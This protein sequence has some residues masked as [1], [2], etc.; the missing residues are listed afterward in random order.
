[1]NEVAD[2][3]S[4]RQPSIV[5]R[6]S[7]RPFAAIACSFS[8]GIASSLLCQH[9]FFAGFAI[10]DIC[11]IYSGF[12]SLLKNRL[13]LS[14]TLGIIA[15]SMGG[16]LMALAN[17]DAFPES[18]LRS[19]ISKLALRLGEPVSSE[20]CVV[21]E[22]ELRGDEIVATID[23][24]AFLDKDRWIVTAGKAMVRIA[25]A[26]SENPG[27]KK[28]RLI[29][30][31]RV[32]GW[33]AWNLPRNFENPG[34]ADSAGLLARRGIILVGKI[35]SKRLLET[36]PGGCIDPWTRIANTIGTHVQNSLDPLRAIEKG[37]R[38]AILASLILGDYSGLANNTREVFQNSGTF[39][40]LVISGLHVAWIAGVL[41]QLLKWVWVPERI[42]YML[43]FFIILLY[44]CVVGFQASISRCLWMVLLYLIGRMIFRKAD[45]VNIL[46]SAAIFLLISQ[47]TWLFEPG[48][49]LSFLSVL[50]IAVTAVPA[51]NTYVTPVCRPVCF[52]GNS[53]RLF[54][55]PGPWHR[56]GRRLRVH[57]ELCIESIEDS[58]SPICARIL[59]SLSRCL[60][61]LGLSTGCAIVTSLAV[62]LW[63]QPLLAFQFN[64]MSWISP[65]ANIVVVPMSSAVLGTGAAAACAAN[66]PW[67]GPRLMG[68]AGSLAALLL[69][70][71]ARI[72]DI[73]G[74][75]QRC[76][77]PSVGWVLGGIL[78]LF[79]WSF[80]EWRRFWI[81][82]AGI[83][84]FLAAVACGS[85]P[86]LGALLEHTHLPG[87][88][89]GKPLWE[90]RQV[91]SLTFLDVGEGD[92]IVIRFPGMR[93]WVLDAGGLR[94]PPSHEDSAY[95]FDIGEAVVSRYLWQL[96][97]NPVDR[98]LISHP[99]M[100]HAGGI[101]AVLRNFKV[102]SFGY[103]RA[104]PDKM[105]SALMGVASEKRIP[106]RQLHTTIEAHIDGVDLQVL[107]PPVDKLF[108]TTNENS[109]TLRLSYH[110]FAAMLT[111]DL[112]KAGETAVLSQPGALDC[113]L[114]KIAHHGSRA[115][116]SN[117]FLDRT[118]PRWAVLSAGRNNPFG[119]P[120][121]ETFH[122]ILRHGVRP[123]STMDQGAITLETDG[124][125][126][127]LKSYLGGILES[128]EL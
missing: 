94:Q 75:W 29:R 45:S 27:E 3:S 47:P 122:R 81:P 55:Q 83:A 68:L 52:A 8:L 125:R 109:L 23:F 22:S 15:I 2:K 18:D 118:K 60:A 96:W 39:H 30:G 33:A 66:L 123:F 48:F 16:L 84:L 11:L 38:A 40:V 77:T 21:K 85:V 121:Q 70:C 37:Q 62:Q 78:L 90:N 86:V 14:F 128:G 65:F 26:D 93:T 113:Q 108:T 89:T 50:A 56:I 126:Y 64:R 25:V 31:D 35:K 61:Y 7:E 5:N 127:I 12:L 112:E 46:L 44:T 119:H 42:R 82:C 74:A 1:M 91:L 73:P 49:Q 95:V 9:Y 24:R 57:C 63:L 79:V 67:L 28:L 36:I 105:I 101:A 116:T 120:A 88:D 117:T 34:S 10:A 97:I 106:I 99:D 51:I 98:V 72:A 92:S 124:K 104:G 87:S 100:D 102:G 54:L 53:E 80:F 114:L 4:N 76:P 19:R 43:V 17:R 6:Q 110:R 13:K 32:R 59:Q 103:A 71:T 20:G 58:L 115:G 111:G 69:S 107:N 41:L